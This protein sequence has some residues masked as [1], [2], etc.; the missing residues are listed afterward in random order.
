MTA[1][2]DAI[3]IAVVQSLALVA[4]ALSGER[5][6]I[7]PAVASVVALGV[8]LRLPRR[9]WGASSQRAESYRT[10]AQ[11]ADD[12][13]VEVPSPRPSRRR[14]LYVEYEQANDAAFGLC[15][16]AASC[17]GLGAAFG[18]LAWY[19][20]AGWPLPICAAFTVAGFALLGWWAR[21]RSTVRAWRD[22]ER[23]RGER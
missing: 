23:E 12:A 2:I 7:L 16:G 11:R 18:A 22:Q 20:H 6:A 5:W 15:A 9:A 4:A 14:V 13:T 19:L 17:G 3:A 10:P 21:C 8:V 1:R